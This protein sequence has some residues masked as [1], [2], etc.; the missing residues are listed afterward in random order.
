MKSISINYRYP[1]RS[2]KFRLPPP[3]I[4]LGIPTHHR[5]DSPLTELNWCERISENEA[6][7]CTCEPVHRSHHDQ[8][9]A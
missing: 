6:K 7:C 4:R 5:K 9:A 8:A 3:I 2:P 1:S